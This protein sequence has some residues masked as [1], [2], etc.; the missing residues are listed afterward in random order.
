M[1]CIACNLWKINIYFAKLD[2]VFDFIETPPN[3]Q[4]DV[5]SLCKRHK[6]QYLAFRI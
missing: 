4:R 5:K 3:S 2:N 6:N 1:K